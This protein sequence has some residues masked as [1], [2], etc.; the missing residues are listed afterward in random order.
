MASAV[1]MVVI[2]SSVFVVMFAVMKSLAVVASSL[3]VLMS[4]VVTPSVRASGVVRFAISCGINSI[5][6]ITI[7]VASSDVT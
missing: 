7:N 6:R 4:A 5:C 1:L 2:V 3:V